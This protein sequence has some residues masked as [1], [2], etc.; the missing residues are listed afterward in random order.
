MQMNI[1]YLNKF[2]KDLNM[3]KKFLKVMVPALLLAMAIFNGCEKDPT[4]A[5]C[6]DGADTVYIN[7]Q[8]VTDSLMNLLCCQW[9]AVAFVDTLDGTRRVP[10]TSPGQYPFE[11][12]LTF[13]HD[14]TCS[15]YSTNEYIFGVFVISISPHHSLILMNVSFSGNPEYND[16]GNLYINIIS[17]TTDSFE[18]TADSLRLF[19]PNNNEYLLLKKLEEQ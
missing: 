2:K 5:K 9:K 13:S 7:I 1:C 6:E 16:D 14:F 8:Q 10:E 19:S 3:K 17:Y 18:V 4:C 12:T 15:G 11:Y